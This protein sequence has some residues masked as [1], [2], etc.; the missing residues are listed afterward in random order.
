M[1][2]RTFTPNDRVRLA[3][4]LSREDNA[5]EGR[6]AR[7]YVTSLERDYRVAIFERADL[8]T[9]RAALRA[10][11]LTGLRRQDTLRHRLTGE[12]RVRLALLGALVCGALWTAGGTLAALVGLVLG[13]AVGAALAL[14]S[15]E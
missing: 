6:L 14:S 4:H 11:L 2:D 10:N 9:E 3:I 1:S 8:L 15:E 12:R 7:E 5:I 13:G